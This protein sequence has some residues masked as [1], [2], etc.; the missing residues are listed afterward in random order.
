MKKQNIHIQ[1]LFNSK[2]KL[3]FN[4]PFQIVSNFSKLIH[5]IYK[6]CTDLGIKKIDFLNTKLIYKKKDSIKEIILHHEGDYKNFIQIYCQKHFKILNNNKIDS[7]C[8]NNE[9]NQNQGEYKMKIKCI[10]LGEVYLDDDDDL[11]E[12][13]LSYYLDCYDVFNTTFEEIEK[14]IVRNNLINEIYCNLEYRNLINNGNIQLSS[15]KLESEIHGIYQCYYKIIVY[16]YLYR[17]I[18]LLKV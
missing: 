2:I 16:F 10:F 17:K 14:K 6:I 4:F 7:I 12:K 18:Y 15:L 8:N 13:R 5:K 1:I 3:K 9:K 11:I